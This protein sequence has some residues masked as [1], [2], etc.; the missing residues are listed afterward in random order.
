MQL[1]VAGVRLNRESH[2][3]INRKRII[4]HPRIR[5][6]FHGRVISYK[7][8]RELIIVIQEEASTIPSPPSAPP[9]DKDPPKLAHSALN[10]KQ[11]TP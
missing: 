9:L 1:H 6:R 4:N 10:L 8:C 11:A 7:G 3:R 5:L 2:A